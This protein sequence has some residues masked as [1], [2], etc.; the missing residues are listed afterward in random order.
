MKICNCW[1]RVVIVKFD[2][3]SFYV[4]VVVILQ[5]NLMF[6]LLIDYLDKAAA[7]HAAVSCHYLGYGVLRLHD[8]VFFWSSSSCKISL[9]KTRIRAYP[10]N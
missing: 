10:T 1:D 2:Y 5:F 3:C 9:L 6:V 7:A 8:L 4:I